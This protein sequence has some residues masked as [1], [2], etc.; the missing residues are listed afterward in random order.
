MCATSCGCLRTTAFAQETPE[1]LR[2]LHTPAAAVCASTA[3][4]LDC[5]ATTRETSKRLR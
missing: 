5:A 2:G 4:G 1:W 3:F